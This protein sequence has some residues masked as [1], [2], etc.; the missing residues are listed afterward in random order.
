MSVISSLEYL[1]DIS[2]IR[3]EVSEL[4][5]AETYI[6]ERSLDQEEWIIVRGAQQ[7]TDD[8]EFTIDDYEFTPNVENFYRLRAANPGIVLSGE[9]HTT[10]GLYL[11]GQDADPENRSYAITPDST[12]VT[13][14]ISVRASFTKTP[15][16]ERTQVIASQWHSNI[17][18]PPGEAGWFLSLNSSNQLQWIWSTDGTGSNGN[19]V[20]S[21]GSLPDGERHYVRVDMNT[22]T[23]ETGATRLETSGGGYAETPQETVEDFGFELDY[24]VD[25]TIPAFDEGLITLGAQWG[26]AGDNRQWAFY[27]TSDNHLAVD[28]SS[29][30]SFFSG[31]TSSVPVPGG[32][33]QRLVFRFFARQT[34]QNVEVMFYIGDDVDAEEWTQVG[35]SLFTNSR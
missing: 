20:I 11:D 12:A 6:I 5:P 29:D 15:E 2:R 22:N 1:D 24:R 4:N 18:A 13:G 9:D 14:D 19:T 23:D 16:D 30:G 34:P 3:I 31:Q 8:A 21:D 25:A 35:S 7:I 26:I 32:D 27:F 10:P 33:D 17:G 28:I